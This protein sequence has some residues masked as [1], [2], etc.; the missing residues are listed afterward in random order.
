MRRN[1]KIYHNLYVITCSLRG[2]LVG[3]CREDNPTL[4]L[5][6]DGYKQDDIYMG[7][8]SLLLTLLPFQI[9]TAIN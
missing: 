2:C 9:V 4:M 7:F 3:E 8:H 6:E 1:L 5:F